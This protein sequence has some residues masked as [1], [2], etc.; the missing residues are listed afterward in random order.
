MSGS[1]PVTPPKVPPNYMSPGVAQELLIIDQIDLYR[2]L[3]ARMKILAANAQINSVD[4]F[5]VMITRLEGILREMERLQNQQQQS[6]QPQQS[7][8]P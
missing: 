6:Q 1:P 3:L 8:Q 5:N 4:E 7:H 2:T